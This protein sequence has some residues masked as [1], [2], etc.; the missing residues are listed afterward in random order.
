MFRFKKL[1]KI[2]TSYLSRGSKV[3]LIKLHQFKYSDKKLED[4]IRLQEDC[5]REIHHD[6]QFS[7]VFFCHVF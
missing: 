4:K 7:M 5:F 1:S 3:D 2:I 6:L